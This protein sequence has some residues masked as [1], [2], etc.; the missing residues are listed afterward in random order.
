MRGLQMMYSV[1]SIVLFFL[2]DYPHIDIIFMEKV[3]LIP[4]NGAYRLSSSPTFWNFPYAMDAK[5][6]A[7]RI[8]TVAYYFL[9]LYWYMVDILSA[10]E[11]S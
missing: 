9:F 4:N 1:K 6:D 10:E 8:P 5:L 11:R 3:L 7:A 2:L